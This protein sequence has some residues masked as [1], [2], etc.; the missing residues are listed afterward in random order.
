[1][2]RWE[3]GL[4][5]DGT[6]PGE[7]AADSMIGGLRRLAEALARLDATDPDTDSISYDQATDALVTAA[8][9]SVTAA[10][11]IL[12]R[13]EALAAVFREATEVLRELPMWCRGCEQADGDLCGDHTADLAR[14]DSY[15]ALLA[16]IN[17][18]SASG[19]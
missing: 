5:G 3:P 11:P 6:G 13:P 12:E 14:A 2:I 9:D 10:T 15:D 4:A 8:R 17:G 7:A 16:A 19:R 18:P 1:M